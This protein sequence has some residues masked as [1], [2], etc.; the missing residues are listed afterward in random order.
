M[1]SKKKSFLSPW[2]A[3]P[4]STVI[5]LIA[6]FIIYYFVIIKQREASLDDRAFR[7]LAAVTTRFQDVVNTYGTVLQGAARSN[8]AQAKKSIDAKRKGVAEAGSANILGFL[9]AQGS[10]L[11]DVDNCRF[12][13]NASVLST[14]TSKK[15]TASTVPRTTAMAWNSRHMAG[16]PT[17]H[18]MWYCPRSLS[19]PLV[20]SSTMYSWLTPQE[21]FSIKPSDLASSSMTWLAGPWRPMLRAPQSWGLTRMV[22]IQKT[23]Q[24]PT[25]RRLAALIFTT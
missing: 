10:K 8:A 6:G 5:V 24:R 17:R 11:T 1:S 3:L 21:P 4:L 15:I 18:S 12:S 16:A 13:P 19:T 22:K 25:P 2:F 9:A 23:L 14:P 20:K 7:N